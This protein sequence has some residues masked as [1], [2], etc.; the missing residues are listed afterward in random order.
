MGRVRTWEILSLRV[1]VEVEA[2][3]TP[4]VVKSGCVGLAPLSCDRS[5]QLDMP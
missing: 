4:I 1:P 3:F 5:M 2:Y